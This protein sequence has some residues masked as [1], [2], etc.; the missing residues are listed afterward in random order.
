ML[1]D[2]ISALRSGMTFG[3][4][5]ATAC[6]L[7]AELCVC[8]ILL[9]PVRAV[10][11]AG[12]AMV[13]QV[14]A[15]DRGVVRQ[16]GVGVLAILAVSAA[17]AVRGI[18]D[19]RVM[20]VVEDSGAAGVHL[21]GASRAAIAENKVTVWASGL[22]AVLAL[23]LRRHA[24]VLKDR[25]AK[26]A[27]L[28]ALISQSRGAQAALE[29]LL[30]KK[31]EMTSP[32]PSGSSKEKER[33]TGDSDA[34]QT[35]GDGQIDGGVALSMYG[36]QTVVS[37]GAQSPRTLRSRRAAVDAVSGEGSPSRHHTLVRDLANARATLGE[38]LSEIE[39]KKAQ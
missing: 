24:Q 10:R 26:D 15:S 20:G 6:T 35:P 23:V 17:D 33:D 22:A 2:A 39:G 29:R 9:V 14:L 25:N 7:W 37:K 36:S 11:R 16:V 13:V 28:A 18:S 27:S 1:R 38:H 4:G 21:T 31:T 3:L 32:E 34:A 12:E 30:A 5:L 8:L 19:A